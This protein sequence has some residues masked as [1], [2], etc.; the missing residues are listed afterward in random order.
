M[1]HNARDRVVFC[2]HC[3]YKLDVVSV[4]S[5]YLEKVS[6]FLR[7]PV[8]L[9]GHNKVV[10]M[11]LQ[12]LVCHLVKKILRKIPEKLRG[13]RPCH[14]PVN[15]SRFSINDIFGESFSA[16][17]VDHKMQHLKALTDP[18][19]W[20]GDAKPVLLVKRIVENLFCCLVE[21]RVD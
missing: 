1:E 9:R 14:V 17:L 8:G 3:D 10:S 15:G 16:V 7:L 4:C 13:L 2:L 6:Q 11:K 18:K 5:Q 21:F 12:I 20:P 19:N